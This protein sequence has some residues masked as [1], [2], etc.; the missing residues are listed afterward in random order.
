MRNSEII[1]KQQ[2]LLEEQYERYKNLMSDY[3]KQREKN[4]DLNLKYII[5]MNKYSKLLKD[6]LSE[7]TENISYNR[8]AIWH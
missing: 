6:C 1:K 4:I 5:L 2:K 3:N 8:R 7:N